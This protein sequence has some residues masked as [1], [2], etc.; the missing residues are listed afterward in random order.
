MKGHQSPLRP[1][2][3]RRDQH[4]QPSDDAGRL[5]S[6]GAKSLSLLS[7]SA[8]LSPANGPTPKPAQSLNSASAV[9]NNQEPRRPP[10]Q[11]TSHGQSRGF[12]ELSECGAMVHLQPRRRRR[13]STDYTGS[14]DT[15][16]GGGGGG[17]QWTTQT[18]ADTDDVLLAAELMEMEMQLHGHEVSAAMVATGRGTGGYVDVYCTGTV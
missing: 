10:P 6:H 13:E 15:S 4:T 17:E 11:A 12:I 16:G 2:H 9:R 5:P 8:S 1:S 18:D 3:Q 14:M 7:P